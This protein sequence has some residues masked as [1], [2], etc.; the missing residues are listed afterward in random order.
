M[1]PYHGMNLPSGDFHIA[2]EKKIDGIN[3]PALAM[4]TA[5]SPLPDIKIQL[6]EFK[7]R[8]AP[9]RG[10]LPAG[11]SA[12]GGRVA[13]AAHLAPAPLPAADRKLPKFERRHAVK[14][15]LRNRT[16]GADEV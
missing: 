14:A 5:R 3:L 6:P 10:F 7:R 4:K 9:S 12:A 8:T 15:G 11:S 2:I 13:Q 16:P 1:I